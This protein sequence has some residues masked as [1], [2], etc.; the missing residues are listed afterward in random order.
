MLQDPFRG[1]YR[2]SLSSEGSAAGKA[3]GSALR[4][5]ARDGMRG[6]IGEVAG[7]QIENLA[8]RYGVR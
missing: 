4:S 7:R 8:I 6:K 1:L 5:F 3:A 2:R